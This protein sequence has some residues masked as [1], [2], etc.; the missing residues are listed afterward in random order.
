MSSTSGAYE[1]VVQHKLSTHFIYIYYHSCPELRSSREDYLMFLYTQLNVKLKYNLG[2][3]G[4]LE[5]LL[6]VKKQIAPETYL[7]LIPARQTS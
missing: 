2:Q 4:E 5:I 1:K 3:E 7:A 6:L